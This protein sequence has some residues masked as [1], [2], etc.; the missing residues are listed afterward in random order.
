MEVLGKA[1]LEDLSQLV[2]LVSAL[3]D[4]ES[5]FQSDQDKQRRGLSMIIEN[6]SAG[7]I[8]TARSDGSIQAMVS[9]LY[10]ISTAEGGPVCWLED[11][12]VREDCR[13]RG[14][15]SRLLQFALDDARSSGFLRV[16]L[17]TDASNAPA[18]AIYRRNG[19]RPSSMIVLR[20]NF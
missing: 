19:F 10:S 7:A 13:K 15:G 5:E 3:L 8:Y 12:F 1:G 20:R 16:S 18:Q 2:D 17:L 11:M 4:Q 14:L 9:L 6:S